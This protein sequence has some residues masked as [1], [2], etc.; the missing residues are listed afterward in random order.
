MRHYEVMIILDTSIDE[1]NV[2]S[3]LERYLEVIRSD[4]GAVENVDIWG[5]RRLAYEIDK[6]SEGIYALL[7]VNAEPA[8]VKELERQLGISET[9]LRT[10]VQRRQ[11]QRSRGSATTKAD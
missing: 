7:D 8:T 11:A 4:G 1:R 6:H 9:V 10:K 5:R 2:S 3:S